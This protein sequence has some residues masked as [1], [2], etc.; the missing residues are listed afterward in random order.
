MAK[1]WILAGAIIIAGFL[2]GGRYTAAG[3]NS[4]IFIVDRYT[5]ASWTCSLRDCWRVESS[6]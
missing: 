5:G 1:T 6:N 4:G 2:I 3:Y